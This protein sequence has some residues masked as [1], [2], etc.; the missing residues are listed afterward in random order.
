MNIANKLTILRVLMIPVFLV[1]LL[2]PA[3]PYHNWIA[4]SIFTAASLTDMLDG[5][6]AR[7]LDLITNFGKFMDPLADKLLVCAA[8]VAL[9]EL[10][11]IAA[12]MVII[13][14]AREF[15]ISGYRLVAADSGTVIAAGIWGKLK[16]IAQILMVALL[17]ADIAAIKLVTEVVIWIA[18]ILT[19]VS[20]VEYMVR[21]RIDMNK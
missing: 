21:N 17:I 1:F 10:G 20:M 7:K 19:L 8:L 4:L 5:M 11:R 14:I 3:L 15:V 16:T 13:I 9:V 2:N 12:W 6:L 18:I